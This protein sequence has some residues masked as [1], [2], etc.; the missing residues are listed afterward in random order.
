MVSQT[1]R[2]ARNDL[3]ELYRKMELEKDP[4]KIAFLRA[5]VRRI[6][7]QKV[8]R[9]VNCCDNEKCQEAIYEG[10][11]VIKV[12]SDGIYCNMRCWADSI[13][14]LTIEIGEEQTCSSR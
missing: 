10:Q 5:E 13:G 8:L 7:K 4:K 3:N 14:A 2:K 6:K 1:R 11:Q 9:K 12:G